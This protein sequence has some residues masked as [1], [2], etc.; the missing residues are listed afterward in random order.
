MFR[1]KFH[2]GECAAHVAY[3]WPIYERAFILCCKCVGLHNKILS[4]DCRGVYPPQHPPTTLLPRLFLVFFFSTRRKH[5]R[6]RGREAAIAEG[7][8]PLAAR[9]LRSV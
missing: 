8:K 1:G 4:S 9:D 3:Y 7:K 5:S 6:R 2:V